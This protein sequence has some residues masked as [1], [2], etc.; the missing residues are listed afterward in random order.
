MAGIMLDTKI[1]QLDVTSRTFDVI[2]LSVVLGSDSEEIKQSLLLILKSIRRINELIL[3]GERIT[4]DIIVFASG[5]NP[6][7]VIIML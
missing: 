2:L 3:A 4:D 7:N 6:K 5:D 1:S